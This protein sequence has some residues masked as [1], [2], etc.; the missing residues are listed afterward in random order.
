MQS[1]TSKATS[2]NKTKLP[3]IYNKID[4]DALQVLRGRNVLDYGCGRYTDHVKAFVE[5]KG[6]TYTGYDP[7]WKQDF[8]WSKHYDVVICSNVLNVIDDDAE[9]EHVHTTVRSFNV[10]YF[11]TV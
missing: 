3:A 1:V 9:M 5:S 10:P 6:F 7:Y 2:I 8:D 11:I 4:W